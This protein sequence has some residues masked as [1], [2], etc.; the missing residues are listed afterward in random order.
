V[1]SGSGEFRD[2]L[3]KALNIVRGA[4][5]DTSLTETIATASAGTATIITGE[6]ERTII[7]PF[8]TEKSLIYITPTSDTEGTTPYL[9]RQTAEDKTNNIRGSF[10]IQIPNRIYKDIN[11][12]WWI[13]N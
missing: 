12:N 9:A 7:S 13:V 11:V 10:T 5:A 3:A 2:V 1:S 6:T 4:Q 8:V